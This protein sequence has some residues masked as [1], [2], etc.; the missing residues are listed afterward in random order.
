MKSIVRLCL[1]SAA[2]TGWAACAF[3]DNIISYGSSNGTGG[4]TPST[5]GIINTV[6]VF[7]GFNSTRD[8]LST[9]SGTPTENI[10]PGTIW[11]GPIGASSWVSNTDSGPSGTSTPPGGTYTFSTT[12]QDTAPTGSSLSLGVYADDTT[13]VYL[14]GN[15]LVPSASTAPAT[16]CDAGQPNCITEYTFMDLNSSDFLLGTNTLTFGVDQDHDFAMGVDFSG[17]FIPGSSLFSGGGTPE[18][19]SLALLGTA[20]LGAAAAFRRRL[21]RP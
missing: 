17:Q 13:S 5:V 14:N 7:N 18:P 1:L 20:M 21:L 6:T 4:S 15:L 3:A 9:G 16:H 2:V 19:S 11:N 12:F 10:G 8:T